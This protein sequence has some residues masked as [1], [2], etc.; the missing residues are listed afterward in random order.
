MF[1]EEEVGVWMISF[2]TI[3]LSLFYTH[4]YAS[5]VEDARASSLSVRS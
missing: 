2:H 4:N 3:L 1:S 5:L